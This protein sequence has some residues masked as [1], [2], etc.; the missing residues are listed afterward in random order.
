MHYKQQ[1][2][3]CLHAES[4]NIQAKHLTSG[5]ASKRYLLRRVAA[6]GSVHYR[7]TASEPKPTIPCTSA[8]TAVHSPSRPSASC[9]CCSCRCGPSASKHRSEPTHRHASFES[10]T[11]TKQRVSGCAATS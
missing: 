6:L 4:A 8:V 2:W 3:H 9:A 11:A 7:T 1:N 10:S 5:F